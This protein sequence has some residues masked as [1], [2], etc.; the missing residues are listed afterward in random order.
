LDLETE[1]EVLPSEELELFE[2][3]EKNLDSNSLLNV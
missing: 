2:A 1:L 3:T